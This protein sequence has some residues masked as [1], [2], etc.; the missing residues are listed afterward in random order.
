MELLRVNRRAAS[1]VTVAGIGRARLVFR[2]VSVRTLCLAAL[3]RWRGGGWPELSPA[4]RQ[5]AG[6]YFKRGWCAVC[7]EAPA[8]LELVRYW[9]L[10]ATAKA[11]FNDPDWTVG[12]KLGRDKSGGYWRLDM[13]RARANPGDIE[14]L[15]CN[16]ATQ[17]GRGVRI[18]FGQDPGQAGK[19]QALHLVRVLSGF[20][21]VTSR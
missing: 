14:K 7:E 3:S 18:G 9:D 17:D 21:G 8:D 16:T 12:I 11:E 10:G 13:V 5:A 2:I 19:S 20:I 6:L 4:R 15:L 1:V